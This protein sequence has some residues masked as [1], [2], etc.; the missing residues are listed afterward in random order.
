ASLEDYVIRGEQFED[1][2]QRMH[3][4]SRLTREQLTFTLVAARTAAFF[5]LPTSAYVFL[6]E[7]LAS[8]NSEQLTM[9]SARFLIALGR[10]PA[11][12]RSTPIDFARQMIDHA[13]GLL[14]NARG[15]PRNEAFTRLD[16]HEL[17]R[18]AHR[19]LWK[20]LR[21]AHFMK[22]TW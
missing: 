9:N 5:G 17:E 13:G 4:R 6:A 8:K 7:I 19:L 15:Q 11:R 12:F 10:A 14:G 16:E 20:L 21:D 3:E 1:A 18:S 22:E 2:L